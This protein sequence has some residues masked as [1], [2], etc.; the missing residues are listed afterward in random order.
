MNINE[1]DSL[2]GF[3]VEEFL[4][5]IDS[6]VRSGKKIGD[7]PRPQSLENELKEKEKEELRKFHVDF[8]SNVLPSVD[9]PIRELAKDFKSYFD[10]EKSNAAQTALHEHETYVRRS[11]QAIPGSFEAKSIQDKAK[12]WDRIHEVIRAASEIKD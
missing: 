8:L 2:G 1:G 7:A 10:A 4:S 3:D 11:G 9:R 6:D 12:R 5:A